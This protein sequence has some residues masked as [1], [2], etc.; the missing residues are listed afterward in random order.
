M[1]VFGVIALLLVFLICVPAILAAVWGA[2]AWLQWFVLGVFEGFT[3]AASDLWRL[4]PIFLACVVFVL[5][6]M[7]VGAIAPEALDWANYEDMVA[8]EDSRRKRAERLRKK[9]VEAPK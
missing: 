9:A 8:A 5:M 2:S 6:V 3:G 1:R 4:P 7:A